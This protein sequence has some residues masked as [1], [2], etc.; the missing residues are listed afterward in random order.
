MSSMSV[1]SSEYVFSVPDDS[2]RGAAP[3]ADR[4]CRRRAAGASRL[5]A[6]GLAQ[7]RGIGGAHV[8][9]PLDAASAQ[10]RRRHRP[11]APQRVHRQALKEGSTR[12][13]AITVRPSGFFHAGC[14]L[15]E[16]FVRCDT[17]GGGQSRRLSNL[18]SSAAARPSRPAALPTCFR[19]HPDM[20]RRATS[21]STSGVTARKRAKT[22][23]DA[24][25]YR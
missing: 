14:D 5:A 19:S 2:A 1:R 17:R 11:D 4:R 21:G 20:P 6:D 15:R 9:E 13:G 8:D 23:C 18:A 25:R 10:P 16:K 22:A 3:P 12:S 7:Q 24:A